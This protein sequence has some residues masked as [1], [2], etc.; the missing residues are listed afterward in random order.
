M[1]V[2]EY[3]L[4]IVRGN[5]EI[6]HIKIL[7]NEVL[8]DGVKHYQVI[9]QDITEQKKLTKELIAAKEKAE[10]SDRLKSAFLANMSHEIRT[11]M[12]GIIGFA[13]LIK[14]KT[15]TAE[16]SYEYISMIEQSGVRLLNLLEEIITISTIESGHVKVKMQETN[17]NAQIAYVYARFKPIAEGK[18]LQLYAKT[19][20]SSLESVVSTD[21][22]KIVEILTNLVKNAIKFSD[23]GTI[24]FGY[25]IVETHCRASLLQFFV[26]DQG[27]GITQRKA[28]RLFLN[29]LFKPISVTKERSREQDLDC[30]SQ[31]HTWKC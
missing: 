16:E 20:L 29:V 30:L 19:P 4:S 1:D 15:L 10:E 21:R 27:I 18:G 3:E 2:M 9:N 24:E 14:E 23:K 11:P 31:K 12:N 13:E 22:E 26:K 8:W 28:G 25:D 17:I 6:R 5:G 7:R